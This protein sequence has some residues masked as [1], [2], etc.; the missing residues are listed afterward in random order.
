MPTDI[1]ELFDRN[2]LELTKAD[3]AEIIRVLR[4]RRQQ[5]ILG[6]KSAGS[7]KP[8]KEKKPIDLSTLDL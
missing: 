5:H 3:L 6:V 4:E 8:D 7:M 1:N 2:P